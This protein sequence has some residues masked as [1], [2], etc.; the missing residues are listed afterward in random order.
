MDGEFI[1]TPFQHFEKV[2]Q[3][4]ASAETM[5]EGS[6]MKMA[7]LKDARAVIEKAECANW[8]RRPDFTQKTNRFGL[9]FTAEAQRVVRRA[10]IGG[11]P[12]FISIQQES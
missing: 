12:L 6:P 7:S 4:L 5:I 9:G 10:R 2:P 8:G 3:T 11:P 1:E